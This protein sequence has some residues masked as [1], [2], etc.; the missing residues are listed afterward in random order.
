MLSTQNLHP[1]AVDA[2]SAEALG[3]HWLPG[4]AA[5]AFEALQAV[6][7]C[8]DAGQLPSDVSSRVGCLPTFL[9]AQ[10]ADA[11]SMCMCPSRRL[12]SM[13]RRA[14]FEGLCG[15]CLYALAAARRVVE[16]PCGTA[17]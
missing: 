15:E 16:L 9:T 4:L 8:I 11:A 14:A 5:L 13:R 2:H 1:L 3:P 17:P 6:A 7:I 10:S 12:A